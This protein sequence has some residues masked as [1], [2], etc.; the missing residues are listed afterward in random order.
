M[1][2]REFE[3]LLIALS[4]YT[5][6]HLPRKI[7]YTA[8]NLN[9]ATRYFP[10]IGGLVGG[11]SG[12]VFYGVNSV[13]STS[14]AIICSILVSV[15]LTGAFHEDGLADFL[16]GLGGG[17]SKNQVLDIMKDS[18]I[19]TFGTIGLILAIGLKWALLNEIAEQ[20]I[21]LV[22]ISAN[23]TSRLNPVFLI[24][25]SDYVGNGKS[26]D[27]GKRGSGATLVIA[28]LCAVLSLALLDLKLIPGV[29]LALLLVFF[30]FRI[31]IL[32]RI[33]GYTGDVLGALQQ[34]T[35]LM[36]YFLVII[37]TAVI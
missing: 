14:L 33:G 31:Y 37:E 15:L 27:V 30:P 36:V 11:I 2:K 32:K 9:K 17:Y 25:S 29:V 12:L 22:L 8:L 16:D 20:Q 18:R 34:I 35:E 7:E 24:F 6:I 4:F 26:K 1:I 23:V 13:T 19:G 21:P 5:R 28:I 3:I 10:L